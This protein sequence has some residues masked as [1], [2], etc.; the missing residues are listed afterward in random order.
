[1]SGEK[2]ERWIESRVRFLLTLCAAVAAVVLFFWAS[3]AKQ[4]DKINANDK[5]VAVVSEKLD[6]LKDDIADVKKTV[7]SIDRKIAEPRAVG[8]VAE[9]AQ[10]KE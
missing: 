4:D 7:E 9:L 5:A 8:G 2:C 1:M 3:Q 6:A 10:A